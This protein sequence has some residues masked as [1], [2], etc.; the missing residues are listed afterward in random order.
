MDAGIVLK[1]P[2][3]IASTTDSASNATNEDAAAFASHLP[4]HV[5]DKTPAPRKPAAQTKDETAPDALPANDTGPAQSYAMSQP[6]APV[7]VRVDGAPAIVDFALTPTIDAPLAAPTAPTTP[8]TAPLAAAPL[9][10]APPQGAAP[11]PATPAVA[12]PATADA[13]DTSAAP[14]TPPAPSA[15]APLALDSAAVA[16]TPLVA[17]PKTTATPTEPLRA[18]GRGRAGAVEDASA[19]AAA[20][21]TA[22]TTPALAAARPDI[23]PVAA[24]AQTAQAKSEGA[25]PAPTLTEIA[26]TTPNA[27][28]AGEVAPSAVH[29]PPTVA[30]TVAQHVIR[31]FEGQST[32]IE[33]R[34][35]PAELG[36]VQVKL[37]VGAD[38]RVTAVV[39]ADNPATLSDLMRS[40]RE[41]ERALESAGLELASGGL[42]FD[43]TDRGSDLK[44]DAGDGGG[45][46]MAGDAGADTTEAAAPASRPFGL[47]SW[48]GVR[49]DVTV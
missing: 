40:S 6:A 34:L 28:R 7:L 26:S 36:R 5:Q 41:L 18:S 45:L 14:Q 32:S 44:D 13:P 38:S 33:V 37:E 8:A 11:A 31:R 12:A 39:A 16:A 4:A 15:T 49:V 17:P 1:T 23:A 29:R 46:R 35:D 25:A 10:A 3:P 24:T 22:P 2:P 42:S 30:Q 27:Q 21:A 19:P 9:Q 48:R 43:L 20:K 47:E